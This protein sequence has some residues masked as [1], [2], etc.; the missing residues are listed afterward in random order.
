MNMCVKEIIGK[1]TTICSKEKSKNHKLIK[2]Y[3]NEFI[4]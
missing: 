2:E 3:W 4:K 1:D